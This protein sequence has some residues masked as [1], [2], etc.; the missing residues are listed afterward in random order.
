MREEDA[1][2][3]AERIRAAFSEKKL[4][5]AKKQNVRPTV[6]VGLATSAELGFSVDRLKGAAETALAEAKR[7]GGD[8]LETYRALY[9]DQI[10]PIKVAQLLILE[11]R[12]PRSLAACIEQIRDALSRITGQGDQAVKRLASELHARLTN[13]D[14]EEIFQAGLHEYLTECLADIGEL[15][16]RLQ[17]AYLGVV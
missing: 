4:R 15:G 14:I 7:A 8:R 9:R 10:F 16:Q 13:A 12:M 17:R 5:A 1:R 2:A 6:S 3:I 11:R